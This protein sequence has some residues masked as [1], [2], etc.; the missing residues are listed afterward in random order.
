MHTILNFRNPVRVGLTIAPGSA[1]CRAGASSEGGRNERHPGKQ[2][3]KYIPSPRSPPKPR[4]K[5]DATRRGRKGEEV[6]LSHVTIDIDNHRQKP[7]LI[8]APRNNTRTAA[9]K[10]NSGR[11]QGSLSRR[12][13]TLIELLVV[14]ATLAG[15][16]SSLPLM[17]TDLCYTAEGRLTYTSIASGSTEFRFTVSVSNSSWSIT[18]IPPSAEQTTFKQVCTAGTLTTAARFPDRVR[19]QTTIGNDATVGIETGDTPNCLQP[20]MGAVWLAY[21]SAGHL[22]AADNGRLEILWFINQ[23]LRHQ[24][25]TTPAVWKT[26]PR[27]PFL[28]T[29]VRYWFSSELFSETAPW[30]RDLPQARVKDNSPRL[31]AAYLATAVTNVGSV[32]LPSVFDFYGYDPDVTNLN[33]HAID[34]YHG[35]LDRAYQG[36][37]AAAF[38]PGFGTKTLV[39][40]ERFTT[41]A[42][43][44]AYVRYATTEKV[45]PQHYDKA[46]LAKA[47]ATSG[48]RPPSILGRLD[49]WFRK[50]FRRP[51]KAKPQPAQSTQI[52]SRPVGQSSNAVPSALPTP[53]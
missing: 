48:A 33:G 2:N 37:S 24:H 41:P 50:T 1:A 22:R 17:A 4:A 23:E 9:M 5:D 6:R 36:A 25:L 49:L 12:A 39:Q 51:S 43:P 15:S 32:M 21:A 28:P 30:H 46:T 8:T 27:P 52:Q 20:G 31:W 44:T 11:R 42:N 7:M 29:S 53:P 40:D 26:Q 45:V 14:I 38:E 35:R 3:K 34:Q 19:S 47:A 10:R 13:F 18:L 16:A